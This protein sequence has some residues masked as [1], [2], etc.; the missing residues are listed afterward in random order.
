MLAWLFVYR[1][2]CEISLNEIGLVMQ[3]STV[4]CVMLCCRLGIVD[5]C[6]LKLWM[7]W[8][9]CFAE[10]FTVL[11]HLKHH[12]LTEPAGQNSENA[13]EKMSGMFETRS[14]PQ[15]QNKRSINVSG[16]EYLQYLYIELYNAHLNVNYN[17]TISKQLYWNFK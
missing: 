6:F 17:S 13:V 9:I 14:K 12:R 10:W 5:D 1:W 16:N 3:T 11:K 8:T 7:N 4:Q 2:M 15:I